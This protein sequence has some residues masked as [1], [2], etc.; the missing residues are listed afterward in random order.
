V[1]PNE[2]HR[3]EPLTTGQ[4]EMPPSGQATATGVPSLF[5]VS[6]GNGLLVASVSPSDL[7]GFVDRM[8]Q[9]AG[10]NQTGPQH[11]HSPNPEPLSPPPPYKQKEEPSVTSVAQEGSRPRAGVPTE[12]R[13]GPN[14][15]SGKKC[16]ISIR[17]L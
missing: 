4:T 13:D 16:P 10:V 6:P 7:P 17:H 14:K 12:V 1:P 3:P 2:Q 8:R 15:S 5:Y 11:G 9:A